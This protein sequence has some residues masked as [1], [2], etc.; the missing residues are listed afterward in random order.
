MDNNSYLNLLYKQRALL[1]A[2]LKVEGK[3]TFAYDH[4]NLMIT[5]RDL[6]LFVSAGKMLQHEKVSVRGKFILNCILSEFLPVF[7][8]EDEFHL[9]DDLVIQKR[10]EAQQAQLEYYQHVGKYL[11]E[12]SSNE[13]CSFNG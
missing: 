6:S 12:D 2:F 13:I 3:K 8:Q 11:M 7:E 10:E 5:K 9:I 1:S 4:F